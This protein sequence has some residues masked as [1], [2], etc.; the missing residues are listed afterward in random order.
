MEFGSYMPDVFIGRIILNPSVLKVKP[1]KGRNPGKETENLSDPMTTNVQIVVKKYREINAIEQRHLKIAVFQCTSRSA[2]EQIKVSPIE[3]LRRI[4]GTRRGEVDLEIS[5]D[6]QKLSGEIKSIKIIS[7]DKNTSNKSNDTDNERKSFTNYY[8]YLDFVVEKENPGFLAY[9]AVPFLDTHAMN[10][11]KPKTARRRARPQSLAR[12]TFRK[13]LITLTFGRVSSDIV[14]LNGKTRNYMYSYSMLRGSTTY[15]GPAVYAAS[16]VYFAGNKITEESVPLQIN[17]KTNTKVIDLRLL[18]SLE[19]EN[20]TIQKNRNILKGSNS[21]IISP[22]NDSETPI[23]RAYISDGEDFSQYTRT[24]AGSMTFAFHVDIESIL[25]DHSN[26]S[27]LLNNPLHAQAFI[28]SASIQSIK[29]F[30]K[31]VS[32]TFNKTFS[33]HTDDTFFR[34]Y[35]EQVEKLIVQSTDKSLRGQRKMLRG[36]TEVDEN[37]KDL[38][39]ASI[40]EIDINYQIMDVTGKV[41]RN[42][43]RDKTIRTFEVHDA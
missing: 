30:R 16:G 34:D 32:T 19:L 26:F 21:F 23:E 37:R 10:R 4:D 39:V 38:V 24:N 40:R 33:K 14:I 22:D 3:F 36:R 25:R 17:K 43:I 5:T 1:R 18:K 20:I 28:K 8:H 29:V 2:F 13:K 12:N 41:K 11:E 42:E 15:K 9:V 7:F 35:D 6:H 31:R 27:S